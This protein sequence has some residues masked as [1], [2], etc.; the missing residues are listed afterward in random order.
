[1]GSSK[2]NK[3]DTEGYSEA[4]INLSI[5]S[6]ESD[7]LELT[8]NDLVLVMDI[9]AYNKRLREIDVAWRDA[10]SIIDSLPILFVLCLGPKALESEQ[11][12]LF[13]SQKIF[14]NLISN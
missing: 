6:Q 3:K 1:M 9:E 11:K 14:G 8:L 5:N 13:D 7:N 2:K 10:R 4:D 12:A